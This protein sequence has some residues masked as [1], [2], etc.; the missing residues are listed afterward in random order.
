M[1]NLNMEEYYK[2]FPTLSHKRNRFPFNK[3]INFNMKMGEITPIAA[4]RTVPG[5]T[6]NL[7]LCMVAK[8]ATLSVPPQDCAVLKLFAFHNPDRNTWKNY[9]YWFGEKQKPEKPEEEPTY[10]VPKVTAPGTWTEQIKKVVDG[11]EINQTITHKGYAFNS[12]YDNIGAVPGVENYKIDAFLPRTDRMIYNTYFRNQTLEDP[13]DI[14]YGDEDEDPMQNMKLR[15]ICKPRDLFTQCLPTQSGTSPV[16]IPLGSAAPVYGT[17]LDALYFDKTTAQAGSNIQL[18]RDDNDNADYLI[19][20]GQPLKLLEKGRNKD[21]SG[22]YA[23]LANAMG[24]PLEG[25]Y[26]A[27][28]YNT[29]QYM[30][31]RG[32]NRYFE[33]LS[34]IYGVANPDGVLQQP[35]FLGS[36]ST[37]IE[38]DT[39]TQ[40]SQT[41]GQS[42]P[43]GNRG[44][45]GYA[46]DYSSLI[47]KSFG[48]FGWIIIYGVVTYYPKYQQGVSKLMDT[49]DPLELF[50]PL[51]NLMGDEAI[52]RSE[53]F[54]QNDDIKNENGESVNNE[55]WG[56]GKRNCRLLYPVN[57]VHG[58]Q[59][60]NYPQSLDANHF[61]EY[62]ENMPTLNKNF[63]KVTDEGFKR[64]LTVTDE[65]QFI[66]NAVITGT[67]D[68]EVPLGAIPQPVPNLT[69][70]I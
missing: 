27:I 2:A 28:A 36:S 13:L 33:H 53:I 55:V 54:I 47:N 68:I 48:E 19:V 21:G 9:K 43:L 1:A 59:R 8:V 7:D 22:A 3:E 67:N 50:N 64:A 42:T 34:N 14:N 25:L 37:M 32:G 31:S 10:L 17:G 23:D 15:K 40:T 20:G 30:T 70:T 51:F 39:I 45:N 29:M 41:S 65:T 62:Y 52:Y 26:Q 11:K 18:G 38:F 58:E 69:S 61:A 57:E 35:E 60:S 16:E 63:D 24:A 4:I 66:C 49:N 46:Q 56:Y 12:F 6:Y 44:A 5:Q